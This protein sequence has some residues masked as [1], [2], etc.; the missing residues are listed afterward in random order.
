MKIILIG[1]MGSGKTTVANILAKKLDLEVI[2]MDD[3]IVKRSGKS[4][5]QI[6]N[7]D[8]EARLRELE[9]KVSK[10]LTN[11]GGCIISSGGGV[12]MNK[13]N[14][15]LLKNKG[16]IIFLKTSFTEIEKRLKNV[17]DRPLFK[18]KLSAEKLFIFR[19]KLY[20]EYAD[21]IVN[22]DGKSVERITN[23][24]ISQN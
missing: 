19:Q 12:V 2:E 1:F 9:I 4:I 20:A 10:S 14:I 18:N 11:R 13:I 17:K 5:S 3:L 24:I 23:E 8:G 22:T 6:F 15:D 21:L 7:E 16:K